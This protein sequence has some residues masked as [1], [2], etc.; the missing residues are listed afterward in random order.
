MGGSSNPQTTTQTV[1]PYPGAVPHVQNILGQAG[2][3]FG[4]TQPVGRSG[5]GT[6]PG[7]SGGIG[8][9]LSG[10][11]GN[12]GEQIEGPGFEFDPLQTQAQQQ[13]I[14][15]SA[16]LAPF[17]EQL[18]GTQGFLSS[19]DLLS[20]D[21]NP[22]LAD[23]AAAAQRPVLQAFE[24]RVLPAL[25]GGAIEAGGFGGSRQGIAEGIAARGV[26][27][28]LAGQS[29]GLYGQAYQQGLDTLGRSLALAPQ[30]LQTS[31]FPS[32]L[33]EAVGTTRQQGPINALQQYADLVARATGGYGT[34]T[35]TA[36]GP[37]S[38]GA[39][40]GLGGAAAGTGIATA[41]SLSN[42]LTAGMAGV[43]ALL[44]LFS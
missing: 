32:S 27:E 5:T 12:T 13:Q 15:L 11:L 20:P 36:P 43:G 9:A 22:Y 24:E 21:S 10:I 34:S 18:L 29:A 2:D 41:L 42:P 8:H 28:A 7:L 40:A 31:L 25:R 14:D 44:G 16:Q 17:I 26:G 4:A 38:G 19:T 1:Q 39:A 6:I 33:L 3:I 37:S 23:V 30:T 35:G